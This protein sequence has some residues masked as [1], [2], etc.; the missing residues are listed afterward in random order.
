M[1]L[2]TNCHAKI[3]HLL[4]PCTTHESKY[5]S[6]FV[7]QRQQT[8]V[9]IERSLTNTLMLGFITQYRFGYGMN[10]YVANTNTDICF[11]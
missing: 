5:P 3:N 7:K 11:K 1:K 2:K 4:S 8:Y 10:I 9:C 6:L